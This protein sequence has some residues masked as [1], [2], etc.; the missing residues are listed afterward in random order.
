MKKSLRYNLIRMALVEAIIKASNCSKSTMCSCDHCADLI[1]PADM[2]GIGF[3]GKDTKDLV[4]LEPN[5]VGRKS[6]DEDDK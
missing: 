2:C 6:Q 5:L 4:H 3:S 1:Y